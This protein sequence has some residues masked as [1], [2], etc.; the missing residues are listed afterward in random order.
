MLEIELFRFDRKI[1]LA[2]YFKPYI[3]ENYSF[4]TLRDLLLDIQAN[5]PYFKFDGVKFVKINGCI[6]NLDESLE[7]IIEKCG[8]F[9]TIYPLIEKRATK[10]LT[11]NNDD[12]VKAYDKFSEILGEEI[13]EAEKDYYLSLEPLFYSNRVLKFKECFIGNSGL[14]FANAMAK[15]YFEKK[16]EILNLVKNEALYYIKPKFLLNDPF[17][18][19]NAIDEL[20]S[21]LGI[22]PNFKDTLTDFS[23]LPEPKKD[24]SN[25]NIAV[26]ADDKTKQFVSHIASLRNFTLENEFLPTNLL[27]YDEETMLNLAGEILFDA[28]DSGADFLLV[29]SSQD[30]NLFDTNAKKIESLF[31]R[32]LY[33]FYILTTTE[34]LE[35]LAGDV[36]KSL[37]NHNLKVKLI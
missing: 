14:V 34:L 35:L 12:F 25:F 36:P 5:D 7:K 31:N 27:S 33:D 11:I 4:N 22:K 15:K 17:E 16:D 32:K 10:D 23:V 19:E 21:L 9:I 2:S 29:N 8:N 20:Q 37:E 30:F 18:T 1:D 28:F 13:A 6:V 3:Y 26:Y 24:F